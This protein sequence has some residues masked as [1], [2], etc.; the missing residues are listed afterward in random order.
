LL[1]RNENE[2]LKVFE[3]VSGG[4]GEERMKIN[5]YKTKFHFGSEEGRLQCRREGEQDE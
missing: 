2:N 1:S 3:D 4:R 5:L